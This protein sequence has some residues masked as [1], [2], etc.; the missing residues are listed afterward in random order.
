MWYKVT[1]IPNDKHVS[2]TCTSISVWHYAAVHAG[3]KKYLWLQAIIIDIL[4]ETLILWRCDKSWRTVS[5]N[6][7]EFLKF[8][9]KTWYWHSHGKV[10][11]IVCQ[12]P[13]NTLKGGGGGEFVLIILKVCVWWW[14][15]GMRVKNE[16]KTWNMCVG[17]GVPSS[18]MHPFLW[19][20][21][22]E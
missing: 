1:S 11:R 15:V 5:G 10:H 21:F 16:E 7:I 14:K 9:Y 18:C 12:G 3:Y 6:C 2:R 22:V 4:Y 17:V 8:S 13:Q 20:L 19:I